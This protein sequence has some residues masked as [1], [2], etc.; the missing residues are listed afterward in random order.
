MGR[1]GELLLQASH[2]RQ[3]T[4]TCSAEKARS[5]RFCVR[6]P[7]LFMHLRRSTSSSVSRIRSQILC[8]SGQE[9]EKVHNSKAGASTGTR[10]TN[11]NAA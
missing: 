5:R 10:Q 4:H 9:T 3:S 8:T 1:Q 6:R 7:S 2:P 11:N